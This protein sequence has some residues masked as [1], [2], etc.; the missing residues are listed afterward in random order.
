MLTGMD[1][2]R[3]SKPKNPR[4]RFSTPLVHDDGSPIPPEWGL[5]CPHCDYDLTGLS[6][7]RCPECGRRFDPHEIWVANKYRDAGIG[8]H[9]PAW[10]VY[11]TLLVALSIV[12]RFMLVKP[13]SLLPLGVLPAFELGAFF[14]NRKPAA[15][16]PVVVALVVIACIVV[17]AW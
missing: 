5:R 3:P 1:S 7:R 16:R 6:N 12:V 10:V 11:C 9:T 8:Y 13:F 14:F 4:F 2:G 15:V 17:W